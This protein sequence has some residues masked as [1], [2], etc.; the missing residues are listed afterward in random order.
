MPE[1]FSAS[2]QQFAMATIRY[3]S[4]CP[5]SSTIN[6]AQT[7]PLFV[8]GCE[9]TSKD[10]RQWVK[11]RWTAKMVHM[12]VPNISKCWEI[13]QEVWKRRDAY[14]QMRSAASVNYHHNS[15]FQSLGEDENMDP[16]FTVKGSLHW[17]QIMREWDCEVSF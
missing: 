7:Y 9:A 10:E 5:P 2:S 3:I 6:F 14:R 16:E 13:T 1:T 12:R 17:A 4:S 11:E 15:A 8:A